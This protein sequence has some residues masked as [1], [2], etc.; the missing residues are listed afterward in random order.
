M[1]IVSFVLS[2]NL[3][4][5]ILEQISSSR[6]IAIIEMPKMKECHIPLPMTTVGTKAA[7]RQHPYQIFVSQFR[8]LKFMSSKTTYF[9]S[10]PK[11]VLEIIVRYISDRPSHRHWPSFIEFS[12][13]RSLL[14]PESILCNVT[15][16]CLKSVTVIKDSYDDG[17]D[18]QILQPKVN[19]SSLF[20]S[21]ERSD[22]AAHLGSLEELNV[23]YGSTRSEDVQSTLEDVASREYNKL[24]KIQ[25]LDRIDPGMM[26]NILASHGP[27][28]EQVS[29]W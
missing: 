3:C 8:T 25:I 5:I 21:C 10:L 20:V 22:L 6:S 15:E 11:E 26:E 16:D 27:Q 9:S 4:E 23:C 17:Y 18:N 13:L 12:T 7:Q 1:C 19:S 24:R 29:V 14:E 2:F 28:L